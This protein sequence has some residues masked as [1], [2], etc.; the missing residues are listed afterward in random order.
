[1]FTV[2]LAYEF[3]D[4]SIA[5]SSVNP[6]F[7]ATDLNGHSGHQTAEEGAA[8]IVRIALLNPSVTAKFLEKGREIAW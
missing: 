2:Q 7:T 5:E 6:S 4:E 3:R 1:M 8:E